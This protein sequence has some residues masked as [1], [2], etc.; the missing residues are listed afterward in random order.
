MVESYD[1]RLQT[2]QQ[3]SLPTVFCTYGFATMN[4]AFII[5]LLVQ[6]GIAL[7]LLYD[8]VLKM[9]RFTCIF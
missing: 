1:G 7:N 2:P 8:F 5:S 3:L 9:I 4:T 6:V